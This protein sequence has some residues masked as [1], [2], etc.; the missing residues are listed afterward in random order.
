MEQKRQLFLQVQ[1][2]RGVYWACHDLLM[3]IGKS[4]HAVRQKVV[5]EYVKKLMEGSVMP[6]TKS[7]KPMGFRRGVK[8][9][10]FLLNVPEDTAL[11]LGTYCAE[12]GV[13][14]EAIITLALDQFLRAHG[15]NRTPGL[16]IAKE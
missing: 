10:P 7:Y 9:A 11:D 2:P 8:L 14:K 3:S 5:A 15:A 12:T 4:P 13:A 16:E 6:E 1:L